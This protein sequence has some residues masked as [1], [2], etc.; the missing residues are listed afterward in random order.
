M[1]LVAAA[2]VASAAACGGSSSSVAGGAAGAVSDEAVAAPPLRIAIPG[3]ESTLQPYSYVTGYPG[4]NMLTLVYDTL[5]ILDAGNEPRPWVALRDVVAAEGLLHTITLRDDVRW[6]DGRPLTSADVQFTLRYYQQHTHGRWTP[7]V[8]DITDITT[9]DAVT[10]VVRLRAPDPSF[11]RRLMADVPLLPQHVWQD[12]SD[13]KGFAGRIG[14]GPFRLTDYRP[15]QSYRL[16][17][18]RAHFA[19]APA[20]P[21]LVLPVIKDPA[22][23]FAALES[24]E[25][26]AS[27]QELAPELVERFAGRAGLA[28]SRGPGYAST[29]LQF[30]TERAPWDRAEVRRAVALALDTN[31]LIKTVLLGRGTPGNPGW[32]HPASAMHDPAIVP[33]HD[34][35]GAQRLLDQAGIVD[36]DGDGVRESAGVPLAPVLLA[37]ANNPARLRAAELVAAQLRPLGLAVQVRAQEATSMTQLIWPDFDVTRGRS[38]D[39]AMFGWSPPMLADPLRVVSLIDGDVRYGTNNIGGYRSSEASALAARIRVTL[40]P[41]ARQSLVRAL[42]AIIAR[43]RPFVVLWYPDLVYAY[44]P[45]AYDRWV[46]QAGQGLFNRLSFQPRAAS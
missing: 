29:L 28:L 10:I 12:V 30:N 45:A 33:A 3:D 23:V 6:H 41:A 15:D 35:A 27:S 31:R 24:G 5:F 39:W 32:L 22:T 2:V 17:A 18:N 44:R 19:G 46:F 40:E 1:A 4:W 25:I 13:P 7:P 43:D 34:L 21:E 20:T 11:T 42:E 16:T 36:G 8:R 38:F 26:D 37:P 9:P 14:S